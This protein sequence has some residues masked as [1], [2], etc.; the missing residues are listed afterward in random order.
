VHYEVQ[1]KQRNVVITEAGY[2]AVEDIL[3]VR[4]WRGGGEE[5]HSDLIHL[6]KVK[7]AIL[8]FVY[9][10]YSSPFFLFLSS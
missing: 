9:T 10:I 7:N 1:E 4:D 6:L 3:Q 2:E 5:T 8:S